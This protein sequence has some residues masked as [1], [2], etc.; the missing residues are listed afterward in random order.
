MKR[1]RKL[2][3]YEVH[4]AMKERQRFEPVPAACGVEIDAN[5][6]CFQNPEHARAAVAQGSRLLPC[7]YCAK[8][9]GI[10]VT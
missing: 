1:R 8:A 7:P 9:L 4:V 10:E 5:T 2:K 3:E 6:W